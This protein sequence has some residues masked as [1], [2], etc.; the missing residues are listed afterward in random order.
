V[1]GKRGTARDRLT[2]SPVPD[3]PDLP[4]SN[5]PRPSRRPS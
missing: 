4:H 3:P 5:S 1:A 2:G